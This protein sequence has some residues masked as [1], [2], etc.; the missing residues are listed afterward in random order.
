MGSLAGRPICPL[1]IFLSNF[2]KKQASALAPRMALVMWT[3]GASLPDS[4]RQVEQRSWRGPYPPPGHTWLQA[5]LPPPP[6]PWPLPQALMPGPFSP[7]TC[8]GHSETPPTRWPTEPPRATLPLWGLLGPFGP[9]LPTHTL[10]WRHQGR[11]LG[12]HSQS[13]PWAGA[14]VSGACPR[15]C[16]PLC[17]KLW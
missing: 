8:S 3:P 5:R 12:P 13:C 4:Q 2:S 16:P 1:S 9:A 17:L 6:L 11:A 14:R 10:F 15:L 7:R